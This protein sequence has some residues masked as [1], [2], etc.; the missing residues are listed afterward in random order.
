MSTRPVVPN[1]LF[2]VICQDDMAFLDARTNLPCNHSFH[3]DCLD[4]LIISGGIPSGR[5]PLCNADIPTYTM[6][7]GFERRNVL[8]TIILLN[9][10]ANANNPAWALRAA[11]LQPPPPPVVAVIPPP[12]PPPPPPPGGGGGGWGGG[13]SHSLNDIGP[14]AFFGFEMD[15]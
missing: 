9:R 4:G 1:P 8:P 2:C 11:A 6:L 10:I 13:G 7:R 5:C 15:P 3:R 14:E 12:L